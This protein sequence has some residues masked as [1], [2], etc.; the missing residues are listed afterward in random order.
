MAIVVCIC[1]FAM[2]TASAYSYSVTTINNYT[3]LPDLSQGSANY[4]IVEYY[5]HDVAGWSQLF[6]ARD[7][8]VVEEDFGINWDPN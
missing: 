2:Q 4:V 3:Y 5:P 1:A 8:G 7:T 6:Y